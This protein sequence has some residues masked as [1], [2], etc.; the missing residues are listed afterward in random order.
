MS[1]I[2]NVRLQLNNSKLTFPPQMITSVC[3]KKKAYK[4]NICIGH[5]IYQNI[6][7][8]TFVKLY[9]GES[10]E[11]HLLNRYSEI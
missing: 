2:N 5:H 8:F 10:G 1:L 9:S 7:T 6:I 11:V 3:S 4:S